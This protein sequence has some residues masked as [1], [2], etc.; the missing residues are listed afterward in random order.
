MDVVG[1]TRPELFVIPFGG[2]KMNYMQSFQ[3]RNGSLELLWEQ[4]DF[5]GVFNPALAKV[6][7]TNITMICGLRKTFAAVICVN[8]ATGSFLSSHSIPLM[9]S[10]FGGI[11]IEKI[12]PN[13]DDLYVLVDHSVLR[14]DSKNYALNY[15]CNITYPSIGGFIAHAAD[16]DL[17][18]VAEFIFGKCVY[19]A[20]CTLRWCSNSTLPPS[21]FGF[22]TGVAN[23]DDD[24]QAEVVIVG[25]GVVGVY[26]HDGTVKWEVPGGDPRSGGSPTIIDLN[27]DQVP[28][29]SVSLL[30]TQV[31]LN[32]SNGPFSSLLS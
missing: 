25:G 11:S 28:D 27:G 30:K 5:W 19:S 13:S 22:F 18:G 8:A 6:P 31:F 26:E 29:V 32:G 1:D 9:A 15:Y 12:F 24:P 21:S 14:F 16:V 4:P 3:F 2:L 17:D 20:N 10:N 23:M 7:H